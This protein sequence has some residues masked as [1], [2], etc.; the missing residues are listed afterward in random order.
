MDTPENVYA[1]VP[2]DAEDF[3]SGEDPWFQLT[4]LHQ[5][6]DG[7]SL[8]CLLGLAMDG[9]WVDGYED[10]VL[11]ALVLHNRDNRVQDWLGL[12]EHKLRTWIEQASH[13]LFTVH[14]RA[15]SGPNDAKRDSVA[16]QEEIW[17]GLVKRFRSEHVVEGCEGCDR[18]GIVLREHIKATGDETDGEGEDD[19]GDGGAEPRESEDED[20]GKHSD[21]GGQGAGGGKVIRT[22]HNSSGSSSSSSWTD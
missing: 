5:C 16:M 18:I 1:D 22:P 15:A 7:R 11:L 8:N 20:E 14:V 13:N 2:S 17:R 6:V 19:E 12:D 21:E 10:D 9:Q 4:V 3:V